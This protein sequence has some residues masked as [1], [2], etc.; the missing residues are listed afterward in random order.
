[1][2]LD[3]GHIY[4]LAMALSLA[5]VAIAGVFLAVRTEFRSRRSARRA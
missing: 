4:G 2:G 3:N 1:M 5:V